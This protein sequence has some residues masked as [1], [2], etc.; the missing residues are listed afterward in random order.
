MNPYESPPQIP[1]S[2]REKRRRLVRSERSLRFAATLFVMVGS[3]A[4]LYLYMTASINI[5][6]RPEWRGG[7]APMS[8]IGP[9][10][11]LLFCIMA[12]VTTGMVVCGGR[13]R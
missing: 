3:Y 7:D 9:L 2:S 10:A 5:W 8:I 4:M 1:L 11:T 13:R 6:N 12:G